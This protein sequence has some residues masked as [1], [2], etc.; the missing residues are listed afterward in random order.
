MSAYPV[1]Q[2]LQHSGSPI[3]L[4]GVPLTGASHRETPVPVSVVSFAQLV[5]EY[6]VPHRETGLTIGL[7]L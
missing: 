2:A 5:A 1:F 4:N 6:G 3:N 7:F